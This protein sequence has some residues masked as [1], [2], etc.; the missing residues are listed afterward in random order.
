MA[1]VSRADHCHGFLSLH[2]LIT[3]SVCSYLI[4][5][6]FFASCTQIVAEVPFKA[7]GVPC[8]VNYQIQLKSPVSTTSAIYSKYLNIQ[9]F[10]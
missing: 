4:E 6:R 10:C 2:V 3:A 8:T 1:A 7:P 5:R 9:C